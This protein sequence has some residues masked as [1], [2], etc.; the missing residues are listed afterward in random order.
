MFLGDSL[1][2]VLPIVEE[3]ERHA[4]YYGHEAE[5]ILPDVVPRDDA[6]SGQKQQYADAAADD[7]SGLVAVAEDVD[8]AG[9]DDEEGPPAFEADA[10]DIE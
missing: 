8:E 1:V 7:G 10:D 6:A 3:Q 9:D 5:H 2:K 4:P